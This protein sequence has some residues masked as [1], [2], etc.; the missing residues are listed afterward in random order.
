MSENEVLYYISKEEFKKRLFQINLGLTKI[1][2]RYTSRML[3]EKN[4]KLQEWYK[5]Q[6]DEIAM[7]IEHNNQM[8]RRADIEDGFLLYWID[9]SGNLS[10]RRCSSEEYQLIYSRRK[11]SFYIC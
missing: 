2:I 9:S 7:D 1:G 6:I 8:A 11:K 4:R 3:E 5:R 10:M